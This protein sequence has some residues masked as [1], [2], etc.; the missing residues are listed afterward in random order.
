MRPPSAPKSGRKNYGATSTRLLVRRWRAL[1]A[2]SQGT[3]RQRLDTTTSRQSGRKKSSKGWR[4]KRR[5]STPTSSSAAAR[6]VPPRTHK[7][8]APRS[9]PAPCAISRRRRGYDLDGPWEPLEAR[10]S[11]SWPRHRCERASTGAEAVAPPR[12]VPVFPAVPREASFLEYEERQSLAEFV[13]MGQGRPHLSRTGRFRCSS[14]ASSAV[15]ARFW[16]SP[17]YAAS[18]HVN[19]LGRPLRCSTSGACVEMLLRFAW[20]PR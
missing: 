12:L 18:T 19:D 8:R 16:S 4:Q 17:H 11:A 1:D 9:T 10:G 7:R 15:E 13:E 5:R 14:T 3:K 2:P 6:R 20:T